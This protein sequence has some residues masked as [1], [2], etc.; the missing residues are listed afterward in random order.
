MTTTARSLLCAAAMLLAYCLGMW[1][2]QE[3]H[4]YPVAPPERVCPGDF[5]R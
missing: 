5:R 4:A 2:E 3:R 1:T